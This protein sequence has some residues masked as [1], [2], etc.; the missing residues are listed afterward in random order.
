VKISHAEINGKPAAPEKLPTGA[1]KLSGK[2]EPGKPLQ[3]VLR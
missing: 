1:W 2:S 3:W